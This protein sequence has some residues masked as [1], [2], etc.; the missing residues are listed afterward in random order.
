VP[1]CHNLQNF[2][3]HPDDYYDVYN[4]YMEQGHYH[5][6]DMV[7]KLPAVESVA[8]KLATWSNE[9][10][11]PPPPRSANYSKISFTHSAMSTWDLCRVI[12]SAKTLK[13]FT[14][15][16]GGRCFPEGGIPVGNVTPIFKSLWIHRQNLEE[17]NLDMEGHTLPKELYGKEIQPDDDEEV[18][19]D[20]QKEYEELWGDEL[21]QLAAPEIPPTC[22]SLKDFPQLKHLSIGAHTLCYLARGTG[23]RKTRI[24]SKS[25]NLVDHIPSTLESLR[26]YG[27]GQAFIPEATQLLDYEYDLDVDAQIEQLALEK[28]AKLP[29]LKILEGVDP[30]IPNGFTVEEWEA[31]NNPELFWQDPDDNRWED[32]DDA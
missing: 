11:V 14:K 26:I 2:N 20:E 6:L 32:L 23:D 12:E 9:A 3:F 29:G 28:D 17:L 15:T 19:E 30:R 25:F 4:E 16:M 8:F 31:E 24:D 10:G 1:Y 22:I 21:Q 7:R 27:Y 5:R 18:T 13:N